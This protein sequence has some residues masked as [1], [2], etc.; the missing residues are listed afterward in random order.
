MLSVSKISAFLAARSSYFSSRLFI[1]QFDFFK[2]MH[3]IF[4]RAQVVG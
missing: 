2:P 1:L 3:D 4:D